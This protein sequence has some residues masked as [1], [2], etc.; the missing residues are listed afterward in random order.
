M[1]GMVGQVDTGN[2]PRA[3]MTVD[4]VLASFPGA[5]NT[6]LALRTG[7]VGCHL[8]RFCTLE[9]VAREY[10]LPLQDLLDKL[11]ESLQLSPK[12]NV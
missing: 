5:A 12:E 4:Q 8:V 7:C 3:Q 6:F 10:K 9:D 11:Q 1:G 2:P